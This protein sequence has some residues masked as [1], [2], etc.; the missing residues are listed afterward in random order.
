MRAEIIRNV[1]FIDKATPDQIAEM[2][3]NVPLMKLEDGRIVEAYHCDRF[4]ALGT[5]GE[6]QLDTRY[7]V[8]TFS[9][10]ALQPGDLI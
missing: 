8:W 3:N 6:A 10:D 5:V 7:N 1:E 9:P 2:P 4:I